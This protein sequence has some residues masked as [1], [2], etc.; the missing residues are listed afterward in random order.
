MTTRSL[1]NEYLG[2]DDNHRYRLR[3]LAGEPEFIAENE[4]ENRETDLG[5]EPTTDPIANASEYLETV[6]QNR[7]QFPRKLVVVLVA[8]LALAA[9]LLSEMKSSRLQAF[10]FHRIARSASFELRAAHVDPAGERL[11]AEDG[12]YDHRLGYA[13]IDSFADSLAWAGFPETAR[14]ALSARLAWVTGL[15]LFPPYREK[16]SGGLTIL[17]SRGNPI[18]EARYPV[19]RFSSYGEIPPVIVKTILFIE[20]RDLLDDKFPYRN[21]AVEWDR[22]GLAILG[23]V[24][25]A[26]GIDMKRIGG[27]TLATQIEKFRHS[28][29]GRTSSAR[30][31]VVQMFSATLRA[32]RD[33]E[34]T[35]GVRR[36]LVL[37]YVNS[38]P[39]SAIPGHGEVNGLGDGLAA[40]YGESFDSM[41]ALLS[42]TALATCTDFAR[43]GEYYRKALSLFLAH[44]RPSHY[45]LSKTSDLGA[46]TRTY[47]ALLAE[48]REIPRDLVAAAGKAEVKVLDRRGA[49]GRLDFL[50][51]KGANTVRTHLMSLLG[52]GKLY[53]LDRLDLAVSTTLDGAVQK[54]VTERL[55][56]LTDPRESAK[57]GISG[58]RVAPG[59]DPRKVV[60]SFTLFERTPEGNQLRV[61]TDNYDQPMNI[62]EGIKLDLGS[63]AKLRTMTHYLEIVAS[64]HDSYAGLS[65]E[66]RRRIVVSQGDR[67]S[68]WAIEHLGASAD[69]SLPRMLE[70]ALERRYSASP[71]EEFFTGGM[72]HT[73][74]NFDAAQDGMT[75]TLFEAF[76]HSINLPFVR[77]MRDI[78]NYHTLRL[79]GSSAR[80]LEN[81]SDTSRRIF[82]EK[83]ADKEGKVFQGQALRKFAGK[84]EAEIFELVAASSRNSPSRMA[85]VHRG[86]YPSAT[87]AE[88]DTFLRGHFPRMGMTPRGVE[89]LFHQY[90]PD[91]MSWADRGYIARVHP[92]ELWAAAYM[93]QHPGASHATAIA[94]G[95][96]A[97][98]DVYVWLFNAPDKS[99][100]DKRI[101]MMLESDA[102]LEIHRAWKRLGYPFASLVPSYATAIGSSA[103]RP[104]SLAELAGIIQSG[105]MGVA[106]SRIT[107][108]HFAQA[109][110]YE[111][112]FEKEPS[113]SERLL[114]PEVAV[115]LRRCLADVV[116]NGTAIRVRGAFR[117]D[118][119][120]AIPVG[121]K[122]GTGDHRYL[123]Y[124]KDGSVI[125]EQVMNRSAVFVYT[126][127]DRFFGTVTAFVPG[128]AAA[129]YTFTSSLP[130]QILKALAPELHSLVKG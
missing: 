2:P 85:A 47:L 84:S 40:W 51:R 69:S 104:T 62:N 35:E 29:E 91:T 44:R 26:V 101:R 116:E 56:L 41:S 55:R 73:F 81:A 63:T 64:L 82:L 74:E 75:P 39:L 118:S 129:R 94:D 89:K 80:I 32:Y 4:D 58:V 98:Q 59:G 17:D 127:G 21:P 13:R 65:S 117:N 23:V 52:V 105:G 125:R 48:E 124:G 18:F 30:E 1:E 121:G 54:A 113:V 14:A 66:D 128:E 83:F 77:L 109:T 31:K 61:Q 6:G 126:I 93:T 37:D 68:R 86:V 108:L 96:A 119:G 95:A 87:F 60:Y 112:V 71:A 27:S 19:R 45:L 78:V 97:R 53:E 130:V 76:R 120:V 72:M 43:S 111:A 34:R 103:D 28:R 99:M 7:A 22:F 50:E 24:V 79:P 16:S 67:L 102:F 3:N 100:Q 42:E 20:N 122:T 8:T 107:R 114:R 115:A 15:G 90:H 106:R 110:P 88:F 9:L 12:P 10:A 92:L 46:L 36:Q 11:R 57:M 38:I 25:N 49:T 33:S 123:V 5:K 70:A